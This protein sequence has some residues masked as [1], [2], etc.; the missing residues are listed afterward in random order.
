MNGPML[1]RRTIG[2]RRKSRAREVS[3]DRR[4]AEEQAAHVERVY[5]AVPKAQR[6]A[7]G[8]NYEHVRLVLAALD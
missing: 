5:H 4:A 8:L 6:T 7:A 2:E 3:H 1:D